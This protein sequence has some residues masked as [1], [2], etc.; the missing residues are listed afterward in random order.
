MKKTKR[1]PKTMADLKMSREDR[2]QFLR[3]RR[4][5]TKAGIAY[6]IRLNKNGIN[7]QIDSQHTS[8][9]KAEH[10]EMLKKLSQCLRDAG[11][12]SLTVDRK[13]IR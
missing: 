9:T 8:K 12:D 2:D 3:L 11:F 10:Q 6:N 5:L 1:K 13:S 7:F 4:S